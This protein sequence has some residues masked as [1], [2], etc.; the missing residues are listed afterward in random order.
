MRSRGTWIACLALLLAAGALSERSWLSVRTC[1][2]EIGPK[3]I[4][5]T[6]GQ[7]VLL[8]ILGGFRTVIA[9]MTW[10]R[11]YVLWE[12]KDRPGCETLMRT[13]CALDPHARYFW[14]NTGYALGYDMAHWEIRRRGGYAKVP[15]EIQ[16]HLFKSYARKGLE[17]L[18]EGVR[19]SKAKAALLVF[20]GQLAEMKLGDKKLAADY[21]RQAA[22]TVSP[23]W[24]AARFCA[25]NE[26]DAG[27]PMEAYVWF[28]NYWL[29]RLSKDSDHAP[30]DLEL[31]RDMETN[32]KI[33]LLSRIP[34]QAWEK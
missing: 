15:K 29:D 3:Q 14:E 24:Y 8:G 19:L 12:R 22:E 26:W 32:L 18:D 2:P 27:H 28:K 4:E 33:N 34:R 11:S 17:V 9:D 16:D 30:D 21:Y 23:P 7:G 13:A 5:P 20:A 6:I 25:R 10:I 1:I 31:I